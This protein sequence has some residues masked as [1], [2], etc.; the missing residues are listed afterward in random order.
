M[1]C[2]STY[3]FIDFVFSVYFNLSLMNHTRNNGQLNTQGRLHQQHRKDPVKRLRELP[4]QSRRQLESQVGLYRTCKCVGW[5]LCGRRYHAG[6]TKYVNCLKE[7]F[8]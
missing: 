6:F 3:D 1:S 8:F 7:I 5:K 4:H 2:D